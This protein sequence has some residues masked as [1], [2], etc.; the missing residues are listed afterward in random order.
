MRTS[1]WERS[2][3]PRVH[4]DAVLDVV[5]DVRLGRRCTAKEDD[6]DGESGEDE[7]VGRAVPER[8]APLPLAPTG[9]SSSTGGRCGLSPPR[10]GQSVSWGCGEELLG[11]GEF[12]VAV[13]AVVGAG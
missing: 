13:V 5:A 7:A 4:G 10:T 12:V 3:L 9:A 11:E 8:L 2:S 1:L 6:E